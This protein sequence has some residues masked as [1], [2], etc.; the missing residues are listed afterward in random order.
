MV[1]SRWESLALQRKS[2]AAAALTKQ[3]ARSSLSLGRG[4]RDLGVRQDT[5]IPAE[6]TAEATAAGQES[7]INNAA[8]R[9]ATL[10]KPNDAHGWST[11]R[12]R[13][14]SKLEPGDL[15]ER[16]REGGKPGGL[17]DRGSNF[18]Q[19]QV[20]REN[21]ELNGTARASDPKPEVQG[22]RLQKVDPVHITGDSGLGESAKGR[23]SVHDQSAQTLVVDRSLEDKPW[24]LQDSVHKKAPQQTE[25]VPHARGTR[26]HPLS[27]EGRLGT[28]LSTKDKRVGSLLSASDLDLAGTHS[29]PT[30][31]GGGPATMAIGQQFGQNGRESKGAM[32]QTSNEEAVGGLPSGKD[33]HQEKG[34]DGSKPGQGV[35]G[36]GTIRG[37]RQGQELEGKASGHSVANVGVGDA[38][39]AQAGPKDVMGVDDSGV[40]SSGPANPKLLEPQCPRH[41]V[42]PFPPSCPRSRYIVSTSVCFLRVPLVFCDKGAVKQKLCSQPSRDTIIWNAAICN[43]SIRNEMVAH[44]VRVHVRIC[45]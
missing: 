2:F 37:G 15:A 35:Q 40:H 18:G 22:V 4:S 3:Y 45:T 33:A 31:Q 17:S 24:Q 16:V 6:S 27:T 38:V 13:E 10:A 36:F 30:I 11:E 34:G 21:E 8:A 39:H 43:M 14:G 9:S 20:G 12:I 26:E 44:Y 25:G 23:G 42:S 5:S 19:N 29:Q 7:G 28:D 1:L 41:E 32:D